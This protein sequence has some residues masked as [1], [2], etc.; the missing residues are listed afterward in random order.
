MLPQDRW[1]LPEGVE[2]IFPDEAEAL[3]Q[4]ARRLLDRFSVWGYRRVMPPVVDFLDSL[5]IGTAHELD[6]QT[7]KLAD[8]ASGR[9]IGLRADMTPQVARIDARTAAPGVPTRL[10]YLGAVF[11]AQSEHLD[12]CRNPLQI[13]AELYGV[14]GTAAAIEVIRLLLESLTVA[15]IE[16]IHLDLGHVGVYRAIAR[17]AGLSSRQEARVFDTLQRK[18]A[19]DLD[20]F[21][22]EL[23][24]AR[25]E[26]A[27]LRALLDLN[28]SPDL[29]AR[30]RELLRPGGDE[31]R[32]ALDELEVIAQG[33]ARRFPG[34]PLNL[35][36][37]E[38]RGYHYHTGVVFAAFVPGL[39]RE[40]ARGGR[41]D[42]IGRVFGCARPAVGFS[43][44]LRT[45]V[46]L[47]VPQ[48]LPGG[49][50]NPVYAPLEDDP[51]LDELIGSLRD[52]G[53]TVIQSL[54][55]EPAI[56]ARSDG[57]RTIRR[58]DGQWRLVEP[59]PTTN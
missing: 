41:Y 23:G 21:L 43:A 15:G 29:L 16:G 38:L 5:L 9:L 17:Q 28:G 22:L 1:L 55:D 52:R 3:E 26:A 27:M 54:G 39:G 33:L 18:D 13:G 58:Q 34:V 6:L 51:A 31:I 57:H 20:Q 45:L 56:S 2:E 7:L 50:A 47:A 59:A 46:R 4:L 49:S 48:V 14:E 25:T 44:D 32:I 53:V 35:D 11:R 8:P 19:T 40:I 30:A 12:S 24:I 42:D 36:L 37:A 10:C